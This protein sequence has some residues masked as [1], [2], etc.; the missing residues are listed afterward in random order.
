MDEQ[1]ALTAALSPGYLATLSAQGCLALMAVEL[2]ERER[3]AHY[4]PDLLACRGQHHWFLADRILGQVALLR[5]DWPAAAAHLADAEATARHE[6]LRPEMGRILLAQAD[7]SLAKG[8]PGSAAHARSLLGQAQALYRELGLDDE[9]RRVRARLH[10][11]PRQPG[12]PPPIPLP[13]G[14]TPRESEV[15]RLVAAGRS[16]REIGRE[17]AI[18]ESTVAKHLTSIFNKIGADN[19]AAA[20]AFAIRRGLA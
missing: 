19:R 18:S 7:L 17:L 15:L 11:L 16:N 6:G 20:T 2:G 5:G 4:Y 10:D 3:A 14:L 8:G 9:V 13:A 1:E 12:A